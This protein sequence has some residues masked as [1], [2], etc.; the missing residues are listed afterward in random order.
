MLRRAA[1][2]PNI[3]LIGLDCHIGSQLL[4]TAPLLES[5]QALLALVDELAEEGIAISHL[6]VGGGIGVR[7]RDDETAPSIADYIAALRAALEGRDLTLVLEPGRSIVANA[8]VLL[9][10][11][12]YL[13]DTPAHHFALV[14]AGMNDF[15]RPALYEAWVD[16]RP[17]T[18]ASHGD[19]QAW[20]IVGPVCE[21]ADFLGHGRELA[22]DPGSVLAVFGAGAYGFA[23]SSNYHTRPRA[24]ELLVDGEHCHVIRVRETIEDLLRGEQLLPEAALSREQPER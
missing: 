13:K 24:A 22:L 1:A 9:T 7:Y 23:M 20:D 4:D 3:D 19:V 5:L 16:I 6:D 2:L 11:V 15:I 12:E 17:V 10:R 18:P 14:D 8:G 21:T